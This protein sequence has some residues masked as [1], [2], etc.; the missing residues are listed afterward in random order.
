MR[1][2]LVIRLGALG[3]FVLSGPAFAA[4][5]AQHPAAAVTL[6]TTP[7]YAALARRLPWFDHVVVDLRPRFWN[8]RALARLRRFLR[9]FDRVYDLQTSARST[10]YG[11]LAGGGPWSG[12][13]RGMAFSDRDPGR[14]RLHTRERLEGQLRQAGIASLPVPDWSALAGGGTGLPAHAVLLVPGAAPHRPGK[15][16]PAERFG[17]LAALLAARGLV[18]VVLGAAADA[19]LAATIRARCPAAL[20]LTGQ[21]SMADLFALAAQAELA[22][23]NDT[24]P[25]HIAAAMGCRCLVLF[26]PESDPSLTAPRLPDG[27]WPMVIRAQNLA[28]LPLERVAAAVA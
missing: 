22:V 25:M 1:R 15:R 4:I 3:D 21:T 9:G 27:G 16:W 10:W 18:P 23:G 20:D 7:P 13:G 11:R 5:R 6:L 14:D 28:E 2:V 8:L 17:D 12:I 19:P 24:G 26:G